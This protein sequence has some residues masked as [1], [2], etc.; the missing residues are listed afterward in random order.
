MILKTNVELNLENL[1]QLQ[2]NCKKKK[3]T[4]NITICAEVK[5]LGYFFI[6]RVEIKITQ[7]TGS[8]DIIPS[9][10]NPSTETPL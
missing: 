8:G 2:Q 4:T 6:V 3:V 9:L 10:S 7:S 5:S 1:K